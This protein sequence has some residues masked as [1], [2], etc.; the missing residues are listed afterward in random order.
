[1]TMAAAGPERQTYNDEGITYGD[2]EDMGKAEQPWGCSG[3]AVSCFD[4]ARCE[5]LLLLRAAICA[6]TYR[7][8][9]ED[10]ADCLLRLSG[11]EQRRAPGMYSA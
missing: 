5:R 11:A 9:A 3:E 4:A 8:S 10:L 2:T 1:M 6:G 7:V